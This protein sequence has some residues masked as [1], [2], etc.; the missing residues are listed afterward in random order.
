MH[1][2]WSRLRWGLNPADRGRFRFLVVGAGRGGTSLLA[3]LLDAHPALEVGF[4]ERSWALL[5]GD[6][7]PGVPAAERVDRFRAAC[8]EMARDHL[9]HM[10]GNK[11]TTEQIGAL[12]DG[13][14]PIDVFYDRIGD[15]RTVFVLR[16]GRACVASKVARTGQAYESAARFWRF[17]AEMYRRV[18]AAG[19]V[20]VRFEDVVTDPEP[21]LRRICEHLGL[22]YA[23]GMVSGTGSTKMRAEYR[24]DGLDAAKAVPP[25]LPPGVLEQI[26][27]D[28]RA[29]GYL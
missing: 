2:G 3:A 22:R 9:G 25:E 13:G 18:S 12:A 24:R 6:E 10:W 15:V 23:P 19:A 4:E 28:L 17:S 27:D 20:T 7:I 26:E 29:C 11:V 21:E 14:D 8:E 5:V 16:D 1:A